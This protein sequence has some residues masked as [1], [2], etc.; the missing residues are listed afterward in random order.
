M[1]SNH[2]PPGALAAARPA[3]G[4]LV[5]RVLAAKLRAALFGAGAT[6]QLGRLRIDGS[7]GRGAMG[8]ILSAFDPVLDR[9]VAVKSLHAAHD[10]RDQLLREAR[11]LAKL[12]HAN[13]VSIYDVVEDADGLYLVMERVDGGD[14]RAWLAQPRRWREVVAL[15]VQV[16]HGLAAAHA[17]G[18]A[19]CDVKP[20]NVVV[21][22]GRPRLIDFGLA[23]KRTDAPS[24]AGTRAYLAPERVAG[25]GG[26]PAADQYAFFASLVEAIEGARPAGAARWRRMPA[27]LE[28][29]CRRGLDPDPA[30]RFPDMPAAVAALTPT[31]LRTKLLVAGAISTAVVA[32]ALAVAARRSPPAADGRVCQGADALVASAWSPA[33]RAAMAAAF[34]ATGAPDAAA[35]WAKVEPRLAR[36]AADWVR[37]RTASCTATRLHREQSVALLDFSMACFDRQLAALTAVTA[38]FATADPAVVKRAATIVGELDDLAACVDPDALRRAVPLPPGADAPARLATLEAGLDAA[39]NLERRGRHREALAETDALLELARGFGHAPLTVRVLLLRAALQATLGELATAEA[40]LRAA[41]SAAAA[42]HDDRR[43]AEVWIRVLDLLAQQGRYDDA[44]TLEPVAV[45]SA[46]RVPDDLPIQGRLHNTLG[47]VYL[48]KARYRD[49]F[50]QYEQALAIQ[51]RIGADGNPALTPALANLGLARWYAGDPRGA[52]ADLEEALARMRADLGPD[53]SSLGYVHQNLGDIQRQLGDGGAATPHYQEAIRIW[54]ASLGADHANLAY[55]YEQL[56]LLAARAGDVATAQEDVAQALALRERHLGAEHPLVPQTLTVVAEIGLADGSR[57]GL[58]RADAAVARAIAIL[59]KLGPAGQ[60]QLPYALE[61][62]A[63]LAERR[64]DLA[65]ALRDRE[66]SLAIRVATLGE[67]HHDTGLSHAQ[68]GRTLLARRAL[69]AADRSFA[70]ALAIFDPEP[71]SAGDAIAMVEGRAEVSAA[72]GRHAEAVA[73]YQ[74]AVARATRVGSPRL[75]EIRAALARA[76]AAAAR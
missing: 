75:P 59:T 58:A 46:E 66:A 41:A 30:R 69:A 53:H 6:V 45:T 10:D 4:D 20:E 50:T 73:L 42:A 57:A 44:L 9:H 19:H 26:S 33:R 37:L 29:V 7:L 35:I 38:L 60:R 1:A 52:R 71:T 62:R 64:H 36:R 15:F 31:P 5:D 63:Q 39:R 17:L 8:A 49:A 11:M 48:A 27:W 51:R 68:L 25:G 54:T 18:I 47:G 12:N 72:R 76:Q 74:D 3:A 40:T 2:P 56:A 16:G 70:R 13:V 61:S 65:A 55:P 43:V 14:L 23:R 28:R 24:H 21:S 67:A 22:A 32:V 34:A